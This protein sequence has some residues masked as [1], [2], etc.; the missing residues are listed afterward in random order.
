MSCLLAAACSA[1]PGRAPLTPEEALET[2]RIHDGFRIEIFAAEPHVRDP[3]ELAFDARG[4]AFVLEMLDYP[5]DPA[6]GQPGRSRI[7]L[8]EDPDA[9]GR[10]DR[11]TVFADD[12]R[13][14]SSLHPWKDG[15]LVA[16]APDILYLEDSDGDG[17]ADRRRV[18]FT[19]FSLGNPQHRVTSLRFGLDNW[20]YAANDG[21]PGAIRFADRPE[22]AP[23]SVLGADLRFRLDRG[24][25]EPAAGPAQFGQTFDERGHRFVTHNTVHVRHVVLDRHYL[26]RNPFLSAAETA[27]DI[28]DHGL[29][30]FQLTPPQAWRRARTDIRQ[31]RYEEQKLGRHEHAAGFFTAAS[32]GVVYAGDTFPA[33]YRGNLFT[34]EVAG[35]L[36]HRDVLRTDGVTFVAS[37]APEERE[38]E[39]LASTDPWFRPA[40]LTVG[41]DGHLYVVDMYR[42]LIE[43]PEFI[44]EAIRKDLD[45]YS[46]TDRGRIYRIVP[47]TAERRRRGALP[48]LRAA[49]AAA[50]VRALT[51]GN[52]WW[53][54][55]AQRLLLERQDRAAVPILR[56]LARTSG[57]APARIHALY[58]LEGLAALDPALLRE[59][60][61][62]DDTG[63]REHA[64]RL[65]EGFPA[66][67]ARVAQMAGDP[68]PRVQFQ[69]ALSLGAFGGRA[70]LPALASLAARHA[71]DR[72]F[73]QALLSSRQGSSAAI[74]DLLL[75]EE[76]FLRGPEEGRQ[77]FLRELAAV[78]GAR[79]EPS[80]LARLLQQVGRSGPLA[81]EGRRVAALSGLANGLALA[82][83]RGVELPAAEAALTRL[84]DD[85]APRVRSAGTAVARHFAMGELAAEAARR[86]LD[87]QRPAAERRDA[88]SLLAAA[89]F[90]RVRHVFERLLAAGVEP[91]LQEAAIAALG[92]FDDPAV[93]DLVIPRWHAMG[94]RVR[95][96]ALDML[97]G[98]VR[99]AGALLAALE[100]GRIGGAELDP[101]TRQRLLGSPDPGVRARA[102]QVFRPDAA[103]APIARYR[104][105]LGR[106]GEVARGAQAFERLCAVCHA[107][108]PQGRPVGP[109]LAGVS[110]RSKQ[111]L[112]EAIVAPSAAVSPE[113]TSY[114]VVTTEG[115]I[116]DG[117]IVVETPGSL[118]L[119]R[120]TGDETVLRSRI[121]EIR[122]SSLS[123]M[124]EGLGDA[125]TEQELA[126][127]LAFLQA[128]HLHGR[129]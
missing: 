93:A 12:L 17:R 67:G 15:L 11:S 122:A 24:L 89:R 87:P 39:F 65:A 84:L 9:D 42:E 10:V 81:I 79:N 62:S 88:I 91:E 44:P 59:G 25:F 78:I 50:L 5:Y 121:A 117:L 8:L 41:P 115:A 113:Y 33:A 46:G 70:V 32:G 56:E 35:N 85:P 58:A 1:G 49:N 68:S 118:T 55:T 36:V 51:H 61:E 92:A 110:N 6:P 95:G 40:S 7:R 111:E 100:E 124:P 101:A 23:V 4:R 52:Q 28:S 74:L 97:S 60:L 69:A 109:D 31:R 22:A 21:Q 90:R 34:G 83:V 14:A 16:A 38:R 3:V 80:E 54:L 86:A 104:A 29:R 103:G 107:A 127:L 64:V 94:P 75:R 102:E 30:M 72:W 128:A 98:H 27:A 125:M 76:A 19:G 108:G 116:H 129:R 53:R 45:F 77:A 47:A 66:L 43:S 120:A 112:L 26:A 13:Q 71:G 126:D 2:F 114:L 99:R 48:D 106:S 82:G 123:L 57:F 20:F 96:R 119:R 63:V 73:R 37:R 105:V 18:L